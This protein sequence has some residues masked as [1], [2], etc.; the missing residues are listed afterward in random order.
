M[1]VAALGVGAGVWFTFVGPLH[2]PFTSTQLAPFSPATQD[3]IAGAMPS[4]VNLPVPYTDQAPTGNWAA[5][6]H[7][8]EEA[9]L[10]M[11]DRYLRGDRSGGVINPLE[12][13]SAIA[14]M[15]PWKVETDLTYSQLGEMAQRH[16][17]WGWQMYAATV[18][19]IRHQLA[20]GRPLI[21]GVRTH[22]L[23]NPN[24]PGYRD[25][26]EQ[27][28]WSVSHYLVVTGYDATTVILNDPG[29][30]RGH[31]YHITYNQ[32]FHAIEDLDA[33]YPY[34]DQGLIFLV[35]APDVSD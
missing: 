35:V 3:A 34:L 32:L 29:I 31:G 24:Y 11:V 22:G 4:Y 19:N 28:E 33:A 26:F 20:L 2:A 18:D 9:S 27:A 7:D 5:S 25:H 15:T 13:R 10:L 16:L 6:Q 30:T 12:A 14:R 21:V 17:G 8:C 23:G 1:V